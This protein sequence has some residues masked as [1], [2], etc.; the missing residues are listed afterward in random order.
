MEYIEAT[1]EELETTLADIQVAIN[2]IKELD[3]IPGFGMSNYDT[4]SEIDKLIAN[5]IEI[6]LALLEL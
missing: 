3:D 2:T 6:K 5:E 4:V 1:K